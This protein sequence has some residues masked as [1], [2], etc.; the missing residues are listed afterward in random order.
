MYQNTFCLFH[1][2][3]YEVKNLFRCEI[4]L[5]KEHLIFL[6]EPVEGQINDSN[7]FPMIR[8]L[9]ASTIY[10]MSYF[11]RHYKLQIL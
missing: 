10:Y 7:G 8:N 2:I 11:I 9:S 6:V 3:L 5:V 1:S 4:F